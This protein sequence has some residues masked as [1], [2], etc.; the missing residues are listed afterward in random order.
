MMRLTR[1]LYETRPDASYFDYYERAHLNHILAQHRPE[2]GMF[3]YMVPLMSGAHRSFSEP[4]D[5][6]WCCVGSG[7]ESHAKHADS[8]Y[9]RNDETLFVN[10]FIPSTLDWDERKAK[11]ALGTDYPF[12]SRVSLSVEE[13][14]SPQKFAVAL[15]APLWSLA[16]SLKVNGEPLAVD[17][18]D[19]GYLVV[20]REWRAG[21]VVE[22]DLPLTL[23][24]ESTP[25]D[26]DTIAL[27]YGPLV[28]AAD[29]GPIETPFDAPA[30]AL[31]GEDILIGVAPISPVEATF[32]TEG[33]GRPAD[34]TFK[35]FFG[36]RDRRTA[37]YFKRYE[38]EQWAA[39]EAAYAEERRRLAELDARSVDSIKLG[40]ETDESAHNLASE[41]SYPVTYRN[42]SGRD[43]RSGG[44]FEF[45]MKAEDAPLALQVTYWGGERER[46]F[47]ILANDIQ[48]ASER[49]EGR[50]TGEFFTA[51]YPIPE[52]LVAGRSSLRIRFQPHA[53]RTAGPSFGVRLYRRMV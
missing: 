38:P 36:Q 50:R 44:F 5:S 34:M 18:N 41:I 29:L 9:W 49:L 3:A 32:R 7:M 26:P 11:F 47:D 4:F 35:P 6:F 33:I 8:I 30:P 20:A 10:L 43:A 42:R 22:L 28:L 51:D 1:T 13:M 40:D 53:G 16:P 39:A 23:R 24:A 52:E 14:A 17:R 15:R 19:R 27:L 25:D 31:V 2:D 48:I 12:E 46:A 37:V 21:D 45:D